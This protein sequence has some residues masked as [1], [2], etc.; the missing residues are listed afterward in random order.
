[1]SVVRVDG[2]RGADGLIISSRRMLSNAPEGVLAWN[3]RLP[4][5]C[6]GTHGLLH[7]KWKLIAVTTH[8]V[9]PG[10]LPHP[11]SPRT[12]MQKLRIVK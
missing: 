12:T 6:D 11:S 3:G 7:N 2:N 10:S 4:L 9:R 1:V 5:K 8:T